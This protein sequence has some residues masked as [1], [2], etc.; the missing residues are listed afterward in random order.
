M[1]DKIEVQNIGLNE[2]DQKCYAPGAYG[3]MVYEGEWPG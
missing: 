3:E 1:A 2:G